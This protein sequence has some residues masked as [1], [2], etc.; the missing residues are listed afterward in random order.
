[1]VQAHY[2]EYLTDTLTQTKSSKGTQSSDVVCSE[3]KKNIEEAKKLPGSIIEQKKMTRRMNVKNPLNIVK[4]YDRIRQKVRMAK[5]SRQKNR[6]Q[7]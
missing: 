3:L 5:K 6:K 1:M 2:K 4:N 7:K